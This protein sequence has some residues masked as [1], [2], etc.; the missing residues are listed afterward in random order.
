L[1]PRAA[2]GIVAAMARRIVLLALLTGALAPAS[3]SGAVF[4]NPDPIALPDNSVANPYPSSIPVT[5]LKGT[6]VRVRVTL[7]RVLAAARDVDVLL[8]GPSGSTILLSD[9]CAGSDYANRTFTFDDAAPTVLGPG[10]CLGLA[11]GA[12]KPTNYDTADVFPTAPPGPYPVGLSN[13]SGGQPNGIWR[14]Y[15]VDDQA[16]DAGAINGGWALDLTTTGAAKKKCKKKKRKN[17]KKKR[18]R[19]KKR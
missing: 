15:A 16:P 1:P 11:D 6:V 2:A 13:F 19:K 7:V 4:S 5:G 10:P 18:C 3:A 8:A 14:L 17:K 12:F 9:A